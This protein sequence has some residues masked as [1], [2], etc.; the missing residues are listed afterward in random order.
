MHAYNPQQTARAQVARCYARYTVTLALV[1]ICVCATFGDPDAAACK[2]TVILCCAVFFVDVVALEADLFFVQSNN[3]RPTEGLLAVHMQLCRQPVNRPQDSCA[4]CASC[5]RV[6]GSGRPR[7]RVLLAQS[8]SCGFGNG[9]CFAFTKQ[10][11]FVT[12]YMIYYY[13]AYM[14]VYLVLCQQQLY[15]NRLRDNAPTKTPV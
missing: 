13:Y 14:I 1:A 4:G 2:V 10:L 11:L 12:L 8:F 7:I 6:R 15:D 9:C 3:E 5:A